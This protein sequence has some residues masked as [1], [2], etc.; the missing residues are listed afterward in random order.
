MIEKI[1]KEK[2]TTIKN[3]NDKITFFESEID[4][5]LDHIENILNNPEYC[6]DCILF[7]SSKTCPL[8]PQLQDNASRKASDASGNNNQLTDTMG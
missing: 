4:N 2:E 8:E 3:A 6:R 5:L 1:E 7:C